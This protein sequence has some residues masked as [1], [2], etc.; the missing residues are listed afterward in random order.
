MGLLYRATDSRLGRA[1]AIKVLSRQ[2]ATDGAAKARFVREA[3]AAS[4][5]D[6]PNIATVYDIGEDGGELFIAMA[7]YEG[8]T[9]KQRLERHALPVDEAVQVLRQVALGLEAAHRAGIV[10]RDIKP[11]NI[12]VTSGGIVKILD[13]GLAKLVSD[14][15]GQGLTEAGQAMGTVLYMSPEQLRGQAVDPRSDLWA[16]GVLAYELLT[17]ISPFRAESGEATA[18]RILNEEPPSLASIPKMPGWLAELV[19]QLLRKDPVNRPSSATE[20]LRQLD[21]AAL[22]QIS[23]PADRLGPLRSAGGPSRAVARTTI[24]ALVAAVLVIAV[25]ASYLLAHRRESRNQANAIKSLAVLPFLNSGANPDTEYL[26]DGIAESLIDNLSQIPEL[27]VI[28]R[29]TAFRYKGKD[30]DLQKLRHELSVDAVLTGQVQQLGSTLVVHADL[31]NPGTGS[32]L[33][34][35]KY[36]RKLTDV[37]TVEED[38]AKT[39]SEKLRTRLAADVQRRITKH[40]TDNPEAYQRYLRGRYFW[41]KR[42]KESLNT[43][44]EYFQQAIELDPNYALAYAGLSD[45]HALLGYYS[46]AP[47]KEARATA[48]AAALKALALD[49]E[50]AEAH[51]SLGI[52][53]LQEWDWLNAERELQRAISLN[54]NYAVAHNWYGLYLLWTGR[55]DQAIAEQTRAQQL[56]PASPV[57]P[58][59]LGTIA[60]SS[61]QVDRG[62][63]QLK[64]AQQLDA[65][66]AFVHTLLAYCYMKGQMYREAVDQLKQGL[67][68]NENDPSIRG[69]LGYAYVQLGNRDLALSILSDLKKRDERVDEA[70]SIASIYL[71]LDDKEQALEWLEKAYQRRSPDLVFLKIGWLYDPLRSD[72][73]FENLLRRIGLSQ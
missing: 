62:I 1:V 12:L 10:H 42:T 45:S 23:Q 54:P 11:A 14:A 6:H 29:N 25:V 68:L 17:G 3:R 35:E 27:R 51:A 56:D 43:A 16:L 53:K 63:A 18:M 50:L 19:A 57:Y 21:S 32:Q 22:A 58:A 59:N 60:C 15:S 39:I 66:T 46:Y 5:L 67:A 40:Y 9:L 61:G 8:E 70:S 4:A 41:N 38:I 72:P 37:L 73:R 31:V 65:N 69:A 34:G 20:V 26:S 52:L 71:A 64:E 7:L 30:A 44:I 49:E 2:L 48:K 47:K 24:A 55:L 36:N 33:W 28:A 13:F